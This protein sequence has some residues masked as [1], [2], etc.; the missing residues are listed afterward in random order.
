MKDYLK[1]SEKRPLEI[2]NYCMLA[3][4]IINHNRS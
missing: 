3:G 2:I 1:F 4:R